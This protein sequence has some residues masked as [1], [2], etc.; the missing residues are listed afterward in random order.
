MPISAE[1]STATLPNSHRRGK[2]DR[3]TCEFSLRS[4]LADSPSFLF[5]AHVRARTPESTV[6][7]WQIAFNPGCSLTGIAKA[8]ETFTRFLVHIRREKVCACRFANR[9]FDPC[10]RFV[11]NVPLETNHLAALK[12][13][14]ISNSRS[15][16]PSGLEPPHIVNLASAKIA[17]H[18]Y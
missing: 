6:T 9:R 17:S 1:K 8:R 12:Y 18:L 13:R 15:L 4:H 14:N 3:A 5:N 10:R 16:G 2:T 11:R 7:F